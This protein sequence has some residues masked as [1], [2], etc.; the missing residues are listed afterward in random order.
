MKLVLVRHGE[1]LH[2]A[3]KRVVGDNEGLSSLGRLQAQRTAKAL[4]PLKP[5]ALYTSTLT[6]ALETAI[7]ISR[8]L[9]VGLHRRDG[10]KDVDTGVLAGLTQDEM[11]QQYPDF[12][13]TWTADPASAVMP[14]GESILKG[15]ERAWETI[16]EIRGLHPEDNVAV[17]SHGFII[18]GL[19]CKFLG[20]PLSNCQQFRLDLASITLVEMSQR[21]I[22][23][24]RYNDQHH[25]EDL[26]DDERG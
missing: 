16:E 14:D 12:M 4:V 17:I 24:V 26:E 5:V 18:A 13:R 6:R 25:L 22:T 10:L 23:L 20:V 1:T 15:M 19:M 3:E 21:G 11:W 9:G 2:N 8:V 7:V